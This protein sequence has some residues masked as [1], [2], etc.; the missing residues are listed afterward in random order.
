MDDFATGSSHHNLCF[1]AGE[2]PQYRATAFTTGRLR[3]HLPSKTQ[4]RVRRVCCKCASR[5]CHEAT[6]LQRVKSPQET[7]KWFARPLLQPQRRTCLV[8][9]TEAI[10]S[11]K[12][13]IRECPTTVSC[14]VPCIG[15]TYL[16][17]LFHYLLR[18][19]NI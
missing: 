4:V 13:Q 18:F 2:W 3:Q 5:T 6:P 14:T 17:G 1:S 7:L 10:D 16:G 9:T 15:S 11:K 8:R 12:D 19:S